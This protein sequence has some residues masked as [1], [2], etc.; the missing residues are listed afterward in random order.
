[1]KICDLAAR[2]KGRNGMYAVHGSAGYAQGEL[3]LPLTQAYE[4]GSAGLSHRVQEHYFRK[5]G[6]I[7]ADG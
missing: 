2:I 3:S 1:M 6:L 5:N 4:P 7:S